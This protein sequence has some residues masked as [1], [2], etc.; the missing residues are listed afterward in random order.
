MESVS[1]GLP[2]SLIPIRGHP[3]LHYQLTWLA[4]QGITDVLLC[5]GHG[6]DQIE[7]YAGDGHQ[8]G[9]QVRYVDEGTPPRGTG[10]ALRLAFD[11][12]QLEDPFLVTY[13]DS[14][15]P[16]DF[17]R[18]WTYFQTRKESALMAVFKNQ[19]RW[20]KSN[21]IFNGQ[22]VT[23]FDKKNPTPA[24][25]YIEYGL[26][27]LHT[28]IPERHIAPDAPCD[29]ADVFERLSQKEDLAGLEVRTRFYEIGSPEGLRDFE[30]YLSLTTS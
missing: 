4:K 5:V 13:G 12:Q 26:N 21:V 24:M 18:L 1:K 23:Q 9:I 11:Q 22:L 27:A 17:L 14:Y 30:S 7:R 2:K 16:I 29:L 28:N 6:A 10:G 25:A 20:G 19:G 15:L 8:W 3:F